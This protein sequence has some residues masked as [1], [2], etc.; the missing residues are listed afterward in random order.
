MQLYFTWESNKEPSLGITVLM[1]MGQ[2]SVCENQGCPKSFSHKPE[3]QP[4]TES[5]KKNV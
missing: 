4:D 3:A 5:K 2:H 1:R